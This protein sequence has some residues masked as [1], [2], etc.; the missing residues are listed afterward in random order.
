MNCFSNNDVSRALLR[1]VYLSW[2]RQGANTQALI[3]NRGTY[4]LYKCDLF[5]T[6]SI[7]IFHSTHSLFIFLTHQILT[8]GWVSEYGDWESDVLD[9]DFQVLS[10][11]FLGRL[12]VPEALASLNPALFLLAWPW[13]LL[14]NMKEA[15]FDGQVKC[16]R[17]Q[18]SV[19]SPGKHWRATSPAGEALE[20]RVRV[21]VRVPLGQLHWEPYPLHLGVW[22]A[23]TELLSETTYEHQNDPSTYSPGFLIGHSL[24]QWLANL[25]SR[26]SRWR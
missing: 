10:W 24:N 8:A 16:I 1:T 7:W 18:R 19:L 6:W 4:V 22:G 20:V 5:H 21:R 2:I 15:V 11:S 3:S 9:R 12:C 14:W 26:L 17:Q 23:E 13:S 25:Y